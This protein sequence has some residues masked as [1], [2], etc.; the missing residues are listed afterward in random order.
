MPTSPPIPDPIWDAL[1]IEAVIAARNEPVLAEL[2]HV[3][4]ID[5]CSLEEALSYR[6]PRKLGHHA[7]SEFYLQELFCSI[8]QADPYIGQQVRRDLMAVKERDPACRGFLSPF[9]YFKGFQALT[10][11]RMGNWLWRNGRY[12]LALYLQSIISEVLAVD[13]HPA[14]RIGAGV[15]LDHAT[16]IVIGETAVVEDDVSMLHEV[17][18]GGTGK[19][20]GDRHPKVRRGVL[21]GAG[22]KLLGNIEIGE[23]A[24]IGGGSVVL[25]DVPPHAT[26]AGVPAK[27]VGTAREDSPAHQ[28]N[29]SI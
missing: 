22:A 19:E 28:M 9:I 18:L 7:V 8:F 23:G 20:T 16:S 13:I 25:I 21:I 26:A 4:V 6:L 12:E 15:L 11:F 5:R 24:K 3:S 27:I 14:A 1:R 10:A 17:T 2:L 29:H